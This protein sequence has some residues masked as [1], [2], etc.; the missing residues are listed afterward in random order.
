MMTAGNDHEWCQKAGVEE[1][2]SGITL[3][4]CYRS[5]QLSGRSRIQ[6]PLAD[7]VA[8]T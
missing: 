7:R 8:A 1:R 3:Q 6:T 5:I 4:E 2:A